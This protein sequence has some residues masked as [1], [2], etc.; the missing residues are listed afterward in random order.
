MDN[1]NKL[2]ITREFG[3][4]NLSLRN[5]TSVFI[6][7]FILTLA[8][9]YSYLT[10]PKESF[11]EIVIPTIYVGTPYPGNSPID[12]ENLV[13]RPI[14]K[15]IKGLN[16][17]KKVSSTS[18]QDY[19]SIVV[20]FNP[21]VDIPKAL[22]DVKDA[23]DKSKK[24]LPN[25]LPDDP[26][27]MEINFSDF[28]IMSINIAGPYDNDKLKEYGEYLQDEIEQFSEIS[29][30][31]ITGSREREIAIL[32]DLYKMEAVKVN[33]Q[34]IENAVSAENVSLSAGDIL[35]DGFRRTVRVTAEFDSTPEISNIIVKHE[36]GDIVYLN[37]VAT[38][39]D[40]FEDREGYARM[41]GLP[42][43]S[44]QVVKRSGENLLNAAAK[45]NKVIDDAVKHR[46]PKDLEV[47][48]TNDNSRYTK[49]QLN[50]LENSIISGIILVTLTLLFFMGL[51]NSLFVSSAIPL[52]M[53]IAFML[54]NAF[55]VTLNLMVLFSLIL[56][57]GL[58]VDNGIVVV[59]NIYR[60]MQEGYSPLKAAKEGVGEVA[61]PIISSTLTTLAAFFPLIFW[62]DIVGEFMKYLP[63]TLIIV[64][65]SSLFVALV[66]NPVLTA[67]FMKVDDPNKKVNKR[68]FLIITAVLVAIAIIFY[69]TGPKIVG[70]LFLVAGLITF[71][72]V[73]IL[74][75]GSQWFQHKM[76]PRIEN[77]YERMVTFALRKRNP[78][79]F[80]GFTILI[81]IL[82]M[83]LLK[84]REPDILFFPDTDPNNIYVYTE[85]PV[86]TDIDYTDSVTKVVEHVVSKVLEPYDT[87]VESV[88][89]NVGQ[90][91]NN[92][93]EDFS[94]SSV[95]NKSR[96]TI[97]FYEYDKRNGVSSS[98]VMDKIR[99]AVKNIA[100]A[101][102][103]VE[104]DNMGP[105]VGKPINI[106]VSGEDYDKLIA[107]T[108]DLKSTIEAAQ[109]PG[110]E[111]LKT[112][113]ET[114]KPQL[115]V[116]VNRDEAR[117]FGLSTYAVASELRTAVFGKEISKF[118]EGEDEYDIRLRLKEKYRYNI[119]NLLNQD[120]TFRD[121]SSGR[122]IQVPIS[123]VADVKYG[124]TYGSVKRKDLDRVITIFSNV[125]KG[126][127]AN[128][129][130]QKIQNLLKSYDIPPGYKVKF[131]GEQEEQNKSSEF[132]F[133]ALLIAIFSIFLILVSQ[134]NSLIKPFIIIG[135]VIFSTIGVLLGLVIFN[136]DFVIIMTGIGIISL[137][138]IVVNNAIVLIDYTDLVRNRK[139]K[140]AGLSEEDHLPHH[141]FIE[142]VIEGGKIRLR[143][144]LLTAITTVLGL[145]P[146]A[147][148]LNI[149]FYT[150]LT[151]FNP[152][153]YF[154]GDNA[155]FWGP[156]AW[157]VVFGLTFATFLT[158]VIVPVMYVLSDKIIQKLKKVTES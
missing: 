122:L 80:F 59:E 89:A 77:F 112:D 88:I 136:M 119:S 151:E 109:I 54:L 98:E 142:A 144:V 133:T 3:L 46:F 137:A 106:E 116:N 70:G 131:T 92:P 97:T 149:N 103:T 76:L 93:M 71:S 83:I 154:G 5:K 157:T 57:L 22:Q 23:V 129:I 105:P 140:E 30:V 132:L 146:L 26:N 99:Q 75:P 14:E 29:R 85:L 147:V 96:I 9:L 33:F 155:A 104:K 20:E 11:P 130:I 158:L 10:M 125:E 44:L 55:G 37:D 108:E 102:I 95:P 39:K 41:N 107:L 67:T 153:L 34:D 90:G 64:L 82:S 49:N 118:K 91:A 15:Q 150:L 61:L 152:Q 113:L 24:D 36:K 8:G 2:I 7:G 27:V 32:A 114:Q 45:I 47:T 19:S 72:N 100:G 18:V 94:Q 42:V 52:S 138:G 21:D 40:S 134:F 74:I 62:K 51:R 115:I 12:M 156:M 31:D 79:Y 60:L 120:I 110:I 38:V 63:I 141:L 13:T 6:L 87:A 73:F 35:S 84:F 111:E 58:L 16:G 117:R 78:F 81:L 50:N 148:G 48:I 43:I 65:S 101:T 123:S 121:Q 86:G 128:E 124:T 135:S 1:Q 4:S 68:K 126:Y 17:I 66:I 56:A 143:P 139:K 28:P 69:I 53:F 25:D 127:N 145:V